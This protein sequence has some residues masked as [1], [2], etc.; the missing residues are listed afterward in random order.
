MGVVFLAVHFKRNCG[1]T[2]ELLCAED[3][4]VPYSR[5]SDMHDKD[6]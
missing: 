1:E 6:A 4:T 2:V 5:S 3:A